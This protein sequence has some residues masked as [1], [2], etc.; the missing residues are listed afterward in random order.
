MLPFVGYARTIFP[1][2]IKC[3]YS[4]KFLGWA[5]NE[6]N[7]IRRT[8]NYIQ[9]VSHKLSRCDLDFIMKALAKSDSENTF[10]EIS[11]SEE[12]KYP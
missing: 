9:V 6:C 8:T 2:I 12:N 5:K 11:T 4:N 1:T 3:H 10:S 7:V